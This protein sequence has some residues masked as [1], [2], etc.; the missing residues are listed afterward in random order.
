MSQALNGI[1]VDE[2]GIQLLM[3]LL[4]LTKTLLKGIHRRQKCTCSTGVKLSCTVHRLAANGLRREQCTVLETIASTGTIYKGFT[5]SGCLKRK[6]EK[7]R[8]TGRHWVR[9]CHCLQ[10]KLPL[11]GGRSWI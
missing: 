4:T 5:E 10:T 9:P 1:K 8:T 2:V 7:S 3:T 11:L 6:F